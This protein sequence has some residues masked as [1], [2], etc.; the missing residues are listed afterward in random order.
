VGRGPLQN[1]THIG[2]GEKRCVAQTLELVHH[3]L[4]PRHLGLDVYVV[5]AQRLGTVK[6]LS[7]AVNFGTVTIDW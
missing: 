3:R 7:G 4:Q 2:D 6:L 5:G 1:K